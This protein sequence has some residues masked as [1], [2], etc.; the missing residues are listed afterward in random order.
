MGGREVAGGVRSEERE[1]KG[2]G[3]V[4]REEVLQVRVRRVSDGEEVPMRR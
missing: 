3:L 2:K 1:G 4:E